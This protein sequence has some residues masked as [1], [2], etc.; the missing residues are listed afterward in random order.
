ME[1]KRLFFLKA[2]IFAAALLVLGGLLLW[3]DTPQEKPPRPVVTRVEVDG[4]Q[5]HWDYTQ[6]EKMELVLHY[7][8]SA[9]EFPLPYGTEA[10][11]EARWDFTLTLSDGS[12]R[13]YRQAGNGFLQKEGANWKTIDPQKAL[14]LERL[15][16]KVPSDAS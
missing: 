3:P 16:G 15:L 6:P 13:H 9:P 10:P 5:L 8:R 14:F 2:G 4:G 7:L 11:G 12:Q 1:E